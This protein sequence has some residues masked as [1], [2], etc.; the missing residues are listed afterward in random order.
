M[1]HFKASIFAFCAKRDLIDDKGARQIR[2]MPPGNLGP[3]WKG[4][5]WQPARQR[6]VKSEFLHHIGISPPR[7]QGV[8]PCAQPRFSPLRQVPVGGRGT[9]RIQPAHSGFGDPLQSGGVTARCQSQKTA[10]HCQI[11][12]VTDSR[13][14]PCRQ[15]GCGR[16]QFRKRAMPGQ[17]KRRF[18]SSMKS[19]FSRCHCNVIQIRQMKLRSLAA[20]RDIPTQPGRAELRQGTVWRNIVN[21]KSS[22]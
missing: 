19:V 20:L 2:Q 16:L 5:L 7:Q 11:Q 14:K 3:G 22:I 10:Q 8:L 6:H 1:D 9:E 4:V 13:G 15:F 12:S 17:T 21:R 18:Q